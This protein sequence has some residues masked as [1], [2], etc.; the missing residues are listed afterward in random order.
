VDV[1]DTSVL[2]LGRRQPE[3]GRWVVANGD[4]LAIVDLVALEYLTGARSASDYRAL[5]EA[6][7]AFPRLATEPADWARVREVHR[8]LALVGLGHQRSVKLPDLLIAAV[9]ERHGV[10]LVHYDADY[11]RIAAV[12]GQATR[13]VVPRGTA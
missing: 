6:L 1:V 5:E 3:I 8:A 2:I 9:A 11:D 13:W 4:R 12:T 7:D 10:G